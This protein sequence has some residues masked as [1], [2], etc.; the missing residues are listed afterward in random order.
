MSRFD[1][2]YRR[3]RLGWTAL[4]HTAPGEGT[5]QVFPDV[6]LATAYVVLRPFF[7]PRRGREGRLG[8]DD[9]QVDLESTHFPGS[10]KGK[11]Q[12]FYLLKRQDVMASGGNG[13]IPPLFWW[14]LARLKAKSSLTRRTRICA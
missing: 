12:Q 9:W 10:V 13:L 6:N 11:G 7:K 4:S 2:F 8:F 3:P 1:R 5:L 14:T